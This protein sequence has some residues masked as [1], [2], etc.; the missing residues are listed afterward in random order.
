MCIPLFNVNGYYFSHFCYDVFFDFQAVYLIRAGGR[1]SG[2]LMFS[3]WLIFAPQDQHVAILNI[4]DH[5]IADVAV[6]SKTS[7]SKTATRIIQVMCL[8]NNWCLWFRVTQMHLVFNVN[9]T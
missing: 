1:N 4:V 8:I 6:I 3:R 2:A 5:D 7:S 9:N